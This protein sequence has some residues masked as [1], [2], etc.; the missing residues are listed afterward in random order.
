MRKI[1]KSEWKKAKILSICPNAKIL[2][3]IEVELKIE[4]EEVSCVQRCLIDA[5]A[6]DLIMILYPR[7]DFYKLIGRIVEIHEQEVEDGEMLQYKWTEIAGFRK[8]K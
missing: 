3:R 6:Y 1:I 8:V 2:H 4:G 5:N 7:L